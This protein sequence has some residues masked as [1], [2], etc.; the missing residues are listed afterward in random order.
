MSRVCWGWCTLGALSRNGRL[1]CRWRSVSGVY[2]DDRARLMEV[3]PFV[4]CS[5][6]GVVWKAAPLLRGVLDVE[7]VGLRMSTP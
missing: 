5:H 2:E 3:Y 7:A 4:S 6:V 1:P